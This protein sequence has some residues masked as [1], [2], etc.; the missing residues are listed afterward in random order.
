MGD[1]LV[2]GGTVAGYTIEAECGRGGFAAVYR[3]RGGD[4]QLAALKVLHQR[5][6]GSP[7]LLERFRREA[8]ALSSLRH[9]RIVEVRAIGELPDGRPFLA[10]EWLGGG[11]LDGQLATRGRLG[12]DEAVAVIED[13]GA[14]L[15]AAHAIDIIHRD[16]KPRNVVLDAGGR[17]KLVD[18]GIAR[19]VGVEH[20]TLTATGELVG[21]PAYMAPE[22]L[23]GRPVDARADVY[24]LAA[25][26]HHLL[27]GQPLFQ[28]RSPYDV[29]EQQLVAPPPRLAGRCA[30][31]VELDDVL[32]R[33]LAKHPDDRFGDVA[34]M[35]AA[36][37]AA[38]SGAP[39]RVVAV[40]AELVLGGDDDDEALDRA[41]AACQAFRQG[42]V[43]AGFEVVTESASSLLAVAPIP[44][45]AS[46]GRLVAG[47]AALARSIGPASLAITV[48]AVAADR[49]GG[50]WGG[51]LMRL[52]AWVEPG[53]GLHLTEA[54]RAG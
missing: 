18:F 41:G 52:R 5:L 35:L 4:G 10:M 2:V 45:A 7:L 46:A 12:L 9:P 1:E 37:R 42:L 24:G 40:F 8:K 15:S 48:H 23:A 14:A 44:T 38:A 21:T 27:V 36:V 43:G 13:V 3:V 31:P 49:A 47:V 39:A 19:L 33:A 22:Q 53:P 51:D 29:A 16:V 54:A 25:L 6:A 34:E 28:G 32:L 17:A 20:A 30:A 50:R 11:D 26:L